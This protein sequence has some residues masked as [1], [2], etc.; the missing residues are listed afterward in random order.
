MKLSR[1]VNSKRTFENKNCLIFP[2]F[3]CFPVPVGTL[4]TLCIPCVQDEIENNQGKILALLTAT[5]LP[6]PSRRWRYLQRQGCQ[7]QEKVGIGN[8]WTALQVKL[9]ISPCMCHASV[10]R[11]SICGG[12]E[13]FKAELKIFFFFQCTC[14]HELSWR[15]FFL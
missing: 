14:N 11:S 1:I 12:S 3:P 2:G 5:R 6:E 8:P 9:Y 10:I 13:K 4:N 7:N 15:V